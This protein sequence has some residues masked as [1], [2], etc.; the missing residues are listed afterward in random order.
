MKVATI[1]YTGGHKVVTSI[2][3]TDAEIRDYFRVGKV[4]NLGTPYPDLQ[5]DNLQSVVSVEI[6]EGVAL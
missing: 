2:N 1:H 3:G 6:A 5:E 4:F